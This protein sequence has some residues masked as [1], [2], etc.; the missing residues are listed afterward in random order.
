M[1]V[2]LPNATLLAV[3]QIAL[4]LQP[5][6]VDVSAAGKTATE[7][8]RAVVTHLF[9]AQGQ[10]WRSSKWAVGVRAR[11]T[12]AQDLVKA[13]NDR[14]IVRSWPMRGTVHLVPAEDIGWMQRLTNPKVL[15]GAP[16][17]R[18][19]LGMSDEA[20]ERVT[21]VSLQ[22]LSGGTSLTRAEL[23]AVWT[24]AGIE[25]QPAWRYHLVWW[26]CQNGLTTFGPVGAGEASGPD[27]SG[28]DAS[29]PD[30]STDASGPDANADAEPRLVLASDW[31]PTP[32]SLDG[33]EALAE[34]AARYVRGR[35]AVGKKD[36]ASWA[37]LP[38]AS[39][40]R[41]LALAVESGAVVEARRDGVAGVAGALWV[42]PQA[43]EAVE[44]SR[45]GADQD[46]WQ[47]LP[48]F[49]EHILGFSD[50]SPQFDAAHLPQLIPGRN[51][52][53]QATVVHNGRAV[54]T[55]RRDSKSRRLECAPF[56]GE[57]IDLAALAPRVAEWA[58]FYG[59]PTPDVALG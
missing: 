36:L 46:R 24:E 43:L 41:G 54:G 16:K 50:R 51:G 57:R 38:A 33:D 35:G 17:R 15:A 49:D 9:A 26:L 29:G 59:E 45:S 12:T 3:R 44:S 13:M 22:A 37:L 34:F 31:I 4:G 7:R 18:A 14:T 32:R 28:P 30:A 58:E 19:F 40:A 11:G 47:L 1:S 56:P 39:A 48:A 8:V 52:M 55:W 20:L 10:D 23:S 2:S 25:W 5:E 6:T 21:E 53:F 42:S 27:A